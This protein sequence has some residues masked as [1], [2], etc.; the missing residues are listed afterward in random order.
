MEAALTPQE[1]IAAEYRQCIRNDRRLYLLGRE[2]PWP[3]EATAHSHGRAAML[4]GGLSPGLWA[5]AALSSAATGSETSWTV[6]SSTQFIPK[7]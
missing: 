3:G 4:T 6:D 2:R 7:S 5:G 1:S